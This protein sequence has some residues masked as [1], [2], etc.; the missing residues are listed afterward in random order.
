MR[1]KISLRKICN[2]DYA[3][4]SYGFRIGTL[5]LSD[6]QMWC[7]EIDIMT[8]FSPEDQIEVWKYLVD[9]LMIDIRILTINVRGNK[10]KST[11][12][13][14][15]DPQGITITETEYDQLIKDQEL[16]RALQNAG[17]DNWE[18]YDSALE[19]L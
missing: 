6:K 13:G 9:I 3:I 12:H 18:G 16:L 1:N 10:M 11:V 19:S 14:N 15:M 7:M 2:N 4:N 5:R 8:H 17:V